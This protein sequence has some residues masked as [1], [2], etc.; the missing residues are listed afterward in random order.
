MLCRDSKT[1]FEVNKVKKDASA[2]EGSNVSNMADPAIQKPNYMPIKKNPFKSQY[3][4]AYS[5]HRPPYIS[6][7]TAL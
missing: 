4:H 1:V 7:V 2:W 5:P 3:P 6:Y